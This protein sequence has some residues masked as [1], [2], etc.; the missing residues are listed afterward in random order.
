MRI[1]FLGIFAISTSLLYVSCSDSTP[2]DNSA[3]NDTVT[4]TATDTSSCDCESAWFNG[5]TILAPNEGA[6]SPFAGETINCDFHQWSWQKFLFLTQVEDG[7]SLPF[8]LTAMEQVTRE[9][10][11]VTPENGHIVLTE[12]HQAGFHPGIMASNDTYGDSPGNPQTVYYSQHIN[13][14]FRNAAQDFRSIIEQYPDSVNNRW[15]FPV[16]ALELKISW[17]DVSA[18]PATDTVNYF[19]TEAELNGSSARV[20]LLGMHVVGVVENHPEFIWATFE[21]NDL[22]AFYDWDNTVDSDI[23]VTS[24]NNLPFFNNQD[25]AYLA[26]IRW[27]DSEDSIRNPNN[28]FTLFEYGTPRV[29]GGDFMSGTSQN[30]PEENFNNIDHLNQSVHDTIASKGINL[31]T[32]YIYN[33]S[34]WMNMDNLSHAQQIDSILS[35]VDNFADAHD[36]GPLRGSLNAFNITMETYE[37]TADNVAIYNIGI[38]SLQSCFTCHGPSSFQTIA[39]VDNAE[40]ATYISHIFMN[41]MAEHDPDATVDQIRVTRRALFRK[42]KNKK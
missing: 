14:G 2:S 37:Q 15:S 3:E 6:T 12:Y 32:N 28:V 26:D 34:I 35:R 9:M 16:G 20:A 10:Y 29:A 31:W 13:S 1:K 23:P 25:S 33:G 17:V 24:N 4:E 41:Y 30:T 5:S 18:L 38:D 7:E 21:H 11:P 36:G 8:F 42:M 27:N 19:I 22:A 39:G 40:S